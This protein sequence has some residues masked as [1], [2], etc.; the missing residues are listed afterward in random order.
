VALTGFWKPRAA[1]DSKHKMVFEKWNLT[2]RGIWLSEARCAPQQHPVYIVHKT[3]NKIFQRILLIFQEKELCGALGFIFIRWD[4]CLEVGRRHFSILLYRVRCVE[5]QG[6]VKVKV[7]Q[8]HYRPRQALR[9]AG[10]WSAQISRQ[11]THEGGKVVS[12]THRP[13]LPPR[14][15]SWYSFLLE[16]E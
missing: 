10:G 14:K 6:W 16:A 7:N 8:S 12:P 3:W 11:S 9:V 13:P 4:A 5:L 1:N 2:H 15:Y